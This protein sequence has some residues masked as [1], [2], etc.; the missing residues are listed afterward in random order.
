M[1]EIAHPCVAPGSDRARAGEP[2]IAEILDIAPSRWYLTGFLVPWNAP[3]SQKQD[4]EDTQG[5]LEIGEAS[6]GGDEDELSPEPPAAQS[7]PN[8]CQIYVEHYH[9]ERNRRGL[10]TP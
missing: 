1:F 4:V 3:V 8:D 10:R 5:G 9:R 6:G 7:P 2:E